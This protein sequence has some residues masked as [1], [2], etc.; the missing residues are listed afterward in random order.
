VGTEAVYQFL[1]GLSG[2]RDSLALLAAGQGGQLIG[3][4]LDTAN[5]TGTVLAQE[6]LAAVV[7]VDPLHEP[8]GCAAVLTFGTVRGKPGFR[9]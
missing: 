1:G 2:I 7:S 9:H 3:Q 8:G 6:R 4:L 5:R